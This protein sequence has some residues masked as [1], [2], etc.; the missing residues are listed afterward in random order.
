MNVRSLSV[1][2]S[3]TVAPHVRV[4]VTVRVRPER[5]SLVTVLPAT[6]ASQLE[7]PLI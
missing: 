6:G 3:V 4:P 7:C 2:V 5:G 1:A